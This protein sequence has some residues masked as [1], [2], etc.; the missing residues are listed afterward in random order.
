M[1][2][3]QII[4][5]V[6]LTMTVVVGFEVYTAVSTKMSVFWVIAPCSL[7]EVYQSFRGTCYLHYQG[8]PEDSH[9]HDDGDCDRYVYFTEVIVT[10]V[11][12]VMAAITVYTFKITVRM[13]GIMC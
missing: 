9:L 2:T 10:T 8:N 1:S 6:V 4:L 5:L 7:V 12:L 3:L 13:V 11:L